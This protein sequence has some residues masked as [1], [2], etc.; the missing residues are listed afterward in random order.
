MACIVAASN[1]SASSTTANGLPLPARAEKTSTWKKRRAAMRGNSGLRWGRPELTK[2]SCQRSPLAPGRRSTR[3]RHRPGV[4]RGYRVRVRVPGWRR[5]A[6]RPGGADAGVACESQFALGVKMRIRWSAPASG[7]RKHTVSGRFSHAARRCMRGA[8]W[9]AA[10]STTPWRRAGGKDVQ[11]Q[12]AALA[13]RRSV[14]SRI[15][16]SAR[17]CRRFPHI[18][19]TPIPCQLPLLSIAGSSS[20]SAALR[21]R[22]VIAGTRL[23]RW[24]KNARRRPVRG[25][26]W[27]CRPCPGSPT[28]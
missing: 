16:G 18:P 6:R 13:H 24:R 5:R 28:N 10:S 3:L 12:V 14:G 26:W 1:P 4:R 15:G 21:C 17:A 7:G 11:V 23:G 9:S 27:W 22:V 19:D 2:R 20:S 8:S 25:C